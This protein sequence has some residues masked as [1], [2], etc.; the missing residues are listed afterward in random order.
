METTTQLTRSNQ[1][2]EALVEAY[3]GALRRFAQ[4]LERGTEDAEDLL[5]ESLVDAY[6][7]FGNFRSG[8]NFYS[9]MSRI[10]TNN[11]LDRVRK[12]RVSTVSLEGTTLEGEAETL[13]VADDSANPERT[14]LTGL[15]DPQLEEALETLL[16][17]QRTTVELCDLQGASYEEA[18]QAQGCPIGTI[19]SRLHRA[20]TALQRF[21]SG[22]GFEG[23]P[24]REEHAR[25]SRRNLL[26]M[27]TAVAAGVVLGPLA[28][29]EPAAA[30]SQEIRVRVW[31]GEAEAP[32]RAVRISRGLDREARLRVTAGGSLDPAALEA[33]DVLILAG[34]ATGSPMDAPVELEIARRVREGRLGLVVT[35]NAAGCRPLER[36]LGSTA[37]QPPAVRHAGQGVTVRVSAPRHPAAAGL[38]EFALPEGVGAAAEFVGPR[39]DVVVLRGESTPEAPPSWEGMAWTIGR[40][41]V[42]CFLPGEVRAEVYGQEAVSQVLRNAVN[43]CARS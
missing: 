20:H 23:E 30:E 33:T 41:R 26:R 39:P 8:S 43:W 35:G 34:E 24:R 25:T 2:F 15:F 6:R 21:L 14:Y 10:I 42:F 12:K 1:E 13:E 11:H 28:G 29:A 5:Q 19:R 4:R 38:G 27:G 17:A 37:F 32:E 16:P 36:V 9:W 3:R 22:N 18:A 40:G 31:S 7:A